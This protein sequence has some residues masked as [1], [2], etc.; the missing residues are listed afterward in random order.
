MKTEIM[1]ATNCSL[2]V[3]FK[4]EHPLSSG[5]LRDKF[6]SLASALEYAEVVLTA[7]YPDDA[8]KVVIWDSNTGEVLAECLPDVEPT[9]EEDEDD[10][11]EDDC[12]YEVGYDPYLGC[13]TWDE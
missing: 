11:Y 10:W 3:Y 9:P 5:D 13:F 6:F 8:I 7:F 2:T 4:D 1:Y 12:D